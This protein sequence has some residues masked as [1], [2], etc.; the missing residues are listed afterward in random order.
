MY[1]HISLTL[2]ITLQFINS[3][4][5]SCCRFS[6]IDAKLKL[7]C[8]EPA[9]ASLW[10][11]FVQHVPLIF[12]CSF[13]DG[14]L[15]RW[16]EQPNVRRTQPSFFFFFHLS[17]FK[18]ATWSEMKREW[19]IKN[20]VAS[21]STVQKHAIKLL[22]IKIKKN[23]L[24]YLNTI[25]RLIVVVSSSSPLSTFSSDCLVLSSLL[26][27]TLLFCLQ[28]QRDKVCLN[29]GQQLRMR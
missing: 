1:H 27:G 22:T 13:F 2:W 6:I 28:R 15:K 19:W 8:T 24:Y 7:N 5:I 11:I 20:D 25:R 21:C 23:F 14:W 17:Q 12:C 3:P 29:G 26:H 16:E 9:A 10:L 4:A 18:N